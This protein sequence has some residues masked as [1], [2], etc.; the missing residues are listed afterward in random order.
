[1]QHRVERQTA[2]NA[3]IS[4][5]R[6]F[7][8]QTYKTF[9]WN[10]SSR[11][12]RTEIFRRQCFSSLLGTAP[13]QIITWQVWRN[14]VRNTRYQCTF[15]TIPWLFLTITVI[16]ENSHPQKTSL[17]LEYRP[18]RS[19]QNISNY[20]SILCNAPEQQRAHLHCGQ[21]LQSCKQNI[22][23]KNTT[24]FKIRLIRHCWS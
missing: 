15:Y 17:T 7:I 16:I 2:I 24:R 10:S 8:I 1:M 13:V 18:N 19:S 4:H 11:F 3:G 22:I 23:P 6:M 12:R 14:V 20:E 21:T 5:N 9:C